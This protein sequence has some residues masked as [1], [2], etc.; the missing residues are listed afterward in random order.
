MN[1]EQELS[2]EARF[3]L[4][5]SKSFRNALRELFDVLDDKKTGYVKYADIACRWEEDEDYKESLP[6]G[7][8]DCLRKVTPNNGLLTFDHLCAA[9]KISL[10]KYQASDLMTR[11][12]IDHQHSAPASQSS[13]SLPSS[14]LDQLPYHLTVKATPASIPI[15][16]PPLERPMTWHRDM[17]FTPLSP[18]TY[19]KSVEH[20]T[21]SSMSSG[22]LNT[23]NTYQRAKSMPQLQSATSSK[24]GP[25]PE[26]PTRFQSDVLLDRKNGKLPKAQVHNSRLSKSVIMKILQNWKDNFLGRHRNTERISMSSGS[27]DNFLSDSEIEINRHFNQNHLRSTTG[28]ENKRANRRH[29]P[30]RHT[31][32]SNGVDFN[33]VSLIGKNIFYGCGS[34]T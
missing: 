12:S 19:A 29:E 4:G 28:F 6:K 15:P 31:V 17:S 2:Q 18:L 11:N 10:L 33:M 32:G 8:V 5:F 1:C 9:I 3:E 34:A 20:D 14:P 7:I 25:V 26:K 30:R 24:N 27:R 23:P 13:S 16:G 21:N 22:M